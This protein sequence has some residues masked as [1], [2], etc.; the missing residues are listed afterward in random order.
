VFTAEEVFSVGAAAEGSA[1][2]WLTVL[3]YFFNCMLTC[4]LIEVVYFLTRDGV[5]LFSFFLALA[6]SKVF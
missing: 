2:F 5:S 1:W 6:A 3:S 4:F